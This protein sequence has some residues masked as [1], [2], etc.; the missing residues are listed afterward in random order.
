MA[1]P[2]E[3]EV[4][5]SPPALGHR[6]HGA[7]KQAGVSHQDQNDVFG[8][9]VPP[10]VTAGDGTIDQGGQAGEGLLLKGLQFG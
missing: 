2:F 5:V 7:L 6:V 4:E 9:K 3:Y 1:E 8:P 10:E